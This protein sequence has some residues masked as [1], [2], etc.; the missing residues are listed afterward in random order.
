MSLIVSQRGEKRKF[1]DVVFLLLQL[2][3]C[4]KSVFAV[5]VAF[6]SLLLQ[7]TVTKKNGVSSVL[8]EV[9]NSV[10]VVTVKSKLGE[11]AYI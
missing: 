6:F 11:K 7:Q 4:Y 3:H 1:C 9:C 8:I 5:T 2:L 10:T